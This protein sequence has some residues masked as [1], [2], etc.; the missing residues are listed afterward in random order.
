MVHIHGGV[1]RSN[2]VVRVWWEMVEINCRIG[3]LNCRIPHSSIAIVTN[4][5][6]RKA[7]GFTIS[8]FFFDR[9]RICVARVHYWFV[10]PQLLT[11]HCVKFNGPK[12]ELQ[13]A[14]EKSFYF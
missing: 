1:V 14:L 13:L 11:T 2:G 5:R 10:S 8:D 12:F 7:R 3:A 4:E 9:S 6:T